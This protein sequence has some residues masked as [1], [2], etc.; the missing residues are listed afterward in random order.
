MERRLE[1]IFD[2][3]PHYCVG[4]KETMANMGAI[5]PNEREGSEI[6]AE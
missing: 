4:E 3:V 2:L 5:Y 6:G 1:R